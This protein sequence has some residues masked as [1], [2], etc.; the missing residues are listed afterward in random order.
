MIT[1]RVSSDAASCAASIRFDR[2]LTTRLVNKNLSANFCIMRDLDVVG[3]RR[4]PIDIHPETIF[5][6]DL[7]QMQSEAKANSR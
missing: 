1:T 6:F 7:D 4:P 2:R 3:L 5:F